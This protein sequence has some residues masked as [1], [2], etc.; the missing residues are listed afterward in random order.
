MRILAYIL[1]SLI[2]ITAWGEDIRHDVSMN[3]VTLQLSAEQWVTTKSAM[4]NVIIN[5][6]LN[7]GGLDKIQDE[8][9]RQL[10]Q[11][12]S[13]GDW[14]IVSF[15]R[16]LDQSGLEKVVI[17]AQARLPSNSL[18]SL[19][20]KAKAIS[21]AGETFTLD[22]I[23]YTP[24][25]DELRQANIDL[26]NNIYVQAKDEVE[27]ITKLYPDQH[28]YVHDVNF[29]AN[30]MNG[31]QPMVMNNMMAA[32]IAPAA[33]NTSLAVGDKLVLTAT[34]I[35]AALPADHNLLKNIT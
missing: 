6:T 23:A 32:R 4:V 31:P 25:Q 26:R 14:H 8:V 1:L 27:R 17:S 11:V 20:D 15:D 24:S 5:A 21:K 35:L 18:S 2:S 33:S 28:Y 12:S 13:L 19:R 34:V 29:I 7:S 22:N 3:K 30:L 16:S 10:A 9:L